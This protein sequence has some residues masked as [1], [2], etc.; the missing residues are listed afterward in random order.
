MA[1]YLTKE[2]LAN[3]PDAFSPFPFW[4]LN[5]D[6]N[7]A[8]IDRQLNAFHEKGICGAVLHPR[9]GVDGDI[10]YLG[11]RFM[12]AIR[13]AVKTAASLGMKVLLYDEG[14]YPSGSCHGRVV[15]ENPAYAAMGLRA[16]G[17]GEQPD[18]DEKILYRFA[19]KT[20]NGKLLSSR[21]LKRNEKPAGGETLLRLA[22]GPTHGTI[23][24]IHEGEDDDQ[25]SAPAAADLM[26]AEAMRC[27]IRLTH[28]RYYECLNDY[29]GSVILGFFTDE[30]SPVG[31]NARRGALAWSGGFD[32]E[33]SAQGL[34]PEELP[35]LYLNGERSDGIRQKYER[36]LCER[37]KKTYYGPISDWCEEHGIRL[38]GHP[39]SPM[40][41]S[42]LTCFG[43]PGQDVVWR[44][45][46]PEKGLSVGG[47]ESAQAKCASDVARALGRERN[48]NECFGCCGKGGVQWSLN[49][50]DMK[51]YM[52]WLFVRG[53]N[54]LIPHAFYYSIDTP[55]KLDRPPDVGMNSIWW[56]D[57]GR[58]SRYIKVMSALNTGCVNGA[59]IAV[60]GTCDTL[61]VDAVKY[62]YRHQIEFNYVTDE[63]LTEKAE[64][65]NGKLRVGANTYDLV[66][67]DP[68]LV[69]REDALALLKINGVKLIRRAGKGLLPYAAVQAEPACAALRV[70]LTKHENASALLIV[71]EGEKPWEGTL[72]LPFEGEIAAFDPWEN[73]LSR[74][75][76]GSVSLR[77][78]GRQSMVFLSGIGTEGLP[79]FR[80]PVWEE[81]VCL[82]KA[83]TLTLPSGRTVTGL[84]DWSRM[85]ETKLYSG[86]LT[87][88]C[89]IGYSGK[90]K[91]LL[92]LGTVR[93]KA[94]VYVNGAYAGTLLTAP[95]EIEISALCRK[96]GNAVEVRV[97]NSPVPKYDRRPYPSG[98]TGKTHICGEKC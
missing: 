56:E 92:K 89:E 53:C 7:D 66:L 75:L 80:E 34:T 91:L 12:H 11:D 90:G 8:E 67:T 98:M 65:E 82:D 68:A 76:G 24:G 37:L 2:L 55:V 73:T 28:E 48:L 70:T 14:M 61:P 30:P 36:A 1:V 85:G 39:H 64:F 13:H 38:C 44:W 17:E 10:V 49:V 88:R 72:T 54:F 93:E 21:V 20:E 42:L 25:P 51:W 59:K 79:A 78:H 83:W 6:L 87:Y 71:N 45:V 74:L 43:I 57:W 31:R 3:P 29:F 16:L 94:K 15:K 52:D 19:V 58:L 40:D 84:S 9:I 77:L 41:S 62:L 50:S 5:G 32:K 4:F 81:G 96:G 63:L 47:R 26:N 22:Y 35:Y 23:R 97:T 33:L 18:G 95:Y 69:Y 86:E 60:L 46:A 27:F